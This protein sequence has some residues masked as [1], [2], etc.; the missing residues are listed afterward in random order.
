M[1]KKIKMNLDYLCYGILLV[2]SIIA[3]IIACIAYTKKPLNN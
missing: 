2:I 3:L 1:T